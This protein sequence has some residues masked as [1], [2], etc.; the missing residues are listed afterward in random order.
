MSRQVS[1]PLLEIDDLTVAYRRGNHWLEAVRDM[2]L[3]LHSGETYGVVGES[4]SGKTTLAM[5]VMRYL[6]KDGRV[7][8]GS[9]RLDGRD[10][11]GLTQAEMRAV[12][13]K[14]MGLVP[15]TPL[16]SLNPSLKVGEQVAEGLRQHMGLGERAA[17]EKTL[18]LLESVRLPEPK[19]VAQSYPH[20]ISG[21]MRQRVLIAAALAT[22]PRLLVL[23]E[24]TTSLDVTTQVSI[25]DLFRELMRGSGSGSLYVT[26]NLG[27]VAQISDRIAVLYAGELVED[28]PVEDLFRQPLHPYT[29]GLLRSIPHVGQHK[30]DQALLPIH[31]Q[32]PSLEMRPEGCVFVDRCPLAIDICHERPPLYQPNADRS[33]RCHRWEEIARGEVSA[34]QSVAI[35][36]KPYPLSGID[37]METLLE[38]DDLYVRFGV[39]RSL[40]EWVAGEP[41]KGVVAVAGVDLVIPQARTVGLVGESGS[42]KT[43]VA[44]AIV[45]LVKRTG[46]E[47]HL[48]GD[49]LPRGL[50]GRDREVLRSIQMVFQNP[51][52]ALNPHFTVGETLQRTLTLLL[53][54]EAGEAKDAVHQ[55][56]GTVRLS[57][58]Y[59]HRL[60]RQ[61]SGGEKQRIATA[62]ALAGRPELLL[63]DEPV[64]SLDV[65]VQ[66]SV[67]NLL[68]ELQEEQAHGMLFISHD[69]AVVGYISDI[70]AVM[71]LGSLMEVASGKELFQPPHHPYTEALLSAIPEPYPK[72]GKEQ[73]LLEGDLPDPANRPAGC[74]F[75]TRCPRFLG[76]ICEEET[77]PWRVVRGQRKRYFCH[78]PVEELI[79]AQEGKR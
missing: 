18:E 67:L 68:Y 37:R 78:I 52:E 46:G 22:R 44:R 40:E 34:A 56:L 71:Y 9:V 59:M 20:Q 7:L 61:L 31:G 39:R 13:G 25:L 29:V 51:E 74:P 6:G 62:R 4:G 53:R 19:D 16:S 27:V 28:A 36:E 11:L 55:L 8:G 49:R 30:R 3:Q 15:Q 12:W 48:L 64:S 50:R 5:A 47:V 72:S 23:D 43:T 75:H 54:M 26:H 35:E 21:G 58:E 41:G 45:G 10:L 42:G 65:S 33:T 1:P 66:A 24:P 69:L 17:R 77:P 38:T 76:D 14:E 57:P 32:M 70:V 2:S 73:I 63:A 60:P 79:E